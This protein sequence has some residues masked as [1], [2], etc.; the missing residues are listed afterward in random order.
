MSLGKH[1]RT[2]QHK[3]VSVSDLCPTDLCSDLPPKGH[4]IKYFTSVVNVYEQPTLTCG[5][6]RRCERAVQEEWEGRV[7]GMDGGEW[8]AGTRGTCMK[9][10]K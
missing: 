10:V 4:S 5:R 7:G 3:L 1:T 6:D 8:E 2:L 9:G